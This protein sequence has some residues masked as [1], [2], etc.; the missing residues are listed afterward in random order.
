M[1]EFLRAILEG[2]TFSAFIVAITVGPALIYL[3][4]LWRY[5]RAAFWKLRF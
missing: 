4:L 1:S 5:D 2:L 3:Y